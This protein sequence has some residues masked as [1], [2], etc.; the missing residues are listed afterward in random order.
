MLIDSHAH[1]DMILGETGGSEKDLIRS[2]KEH[3]LGYAVQVSIDP[4]SLRWSREFALRNA[5]G[6][7]Y[8]TAGVH[9][10]SAAG[11]DELSGLE[12]A[13]G[14]IMNSGEKE[15]FFGIGECGLDYYRMRRPKEE[16][17]RSF[18][19]QID[20]ARKHG[21]P[22]IVHSRD[23]LDDTVAVLK[24]KSP[25]RGIIHCFPG[26][27]DDAA[28]FLD[29]GMYISFAGNVTYNN[30][31]AIRDA[32]ARVPLDRIL[33]E[34]DAPFLTPVPL[35]GKKNTPHYIVHTYRFLAS[36]RKESVEKIEDA[37]ASN[38]FALIGKPA[39]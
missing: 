10:S 19:F 16:Q 25:L 7:F 14:E 31:A 36:L 30:A 21:V 11:N 37:V 15:N 23:A 20:L 17:L 3:G 1:F 35:R 5:G 32:A 33:L 4:E 2:M 26:D 9:P 39:E 24:K 22:V 29:L 38:F 12:S 13:V 27:G 8:F 28:R 34:T 6:G 18:E